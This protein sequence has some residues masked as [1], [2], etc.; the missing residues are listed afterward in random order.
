MSLL[1]KQQ[2]FIY[3]IHHIT[4]LTKY[5]NVYF[6]FCYN[7]EKGLYETVTLSTLDHPYLTRQ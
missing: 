5:L 1:Q 2:P 4:A 6:I 7:L 3:D